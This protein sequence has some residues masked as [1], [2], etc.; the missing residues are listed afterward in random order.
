VKYS[1]IIGDSK[2]F[3]EKINYRSSGH[4]IRFSIYSGCYL[5]GYNAVGE[6]RIFHN[7]W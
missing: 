3:N 4:N 6:D 5:T 7:V 1:L 2:K